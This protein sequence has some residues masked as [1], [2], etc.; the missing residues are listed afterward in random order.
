M[1]HTWRRLAVLGALM[2]SGATACS[3]EPTDPVVVETGVTV[4]GLKFTLTGATLTSVDAAIPTP[5]ASFAAPTVSVNR[6]PSSSVPAVISVAAAEPFQTILVR[7]TGSTSHARI[8]LPAAT[9]LIQISVVTTGTGGVVATS[10][11]IAVGNGA[12]TSA[13]SN[14]ALQALGN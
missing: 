2:L 13:T 9:S 11:T 5:T 4:S 10:V 7:P 1:M 14:L 12:R 6:A 8:F 3:D